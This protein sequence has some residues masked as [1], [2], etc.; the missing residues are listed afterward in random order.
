MSFSLLYFAS[1]YKEF[2]TSKLDN[3]YQCAFIYEIRYRGKLR[4]PTLLLI[5]NFFSHDKSISKQHVCVL[6]NRFSQNFDHFNLQQF[7]T[8]I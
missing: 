3:A 6:K 4:A 8:S 1:V 2:M 5:F 7:T